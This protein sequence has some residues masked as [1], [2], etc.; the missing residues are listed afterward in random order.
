LNKK[1]SAKKRSSLFSI[2]FTTIG[3]QTNKKH[4]VQNRGKFT[5][6]YTISK[7]AQKQKNKK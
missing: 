5:S 2:S 1:F 3:A 7:M 4:Q 6:K